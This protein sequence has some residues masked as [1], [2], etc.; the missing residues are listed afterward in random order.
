MTLRIADDLDL[1]F[2]VLPQR[3]RNSLQQLDR[4]SDLIEIV[5]DLGRLPEARFTDQHPL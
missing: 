3:I 5:M 4:A 1:L 2:A